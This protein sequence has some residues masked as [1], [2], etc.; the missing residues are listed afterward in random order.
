[1]PKDILS[2][3]QLRQIKRARVRHGGKKVITDDIKKLKSLAIEVD[4]TEDEKINFYREPIEIEYYIPKESRF[5]VDI[6][7]LYIR[8]VDPKPK[9]ENQEMIF[10]YFRENKKVYDVVAVMNLYPQFLMEILTA[11]EHKMSI[12]ENLSRL[13]KAGEKGE[14]TEYKKCIYILEAL[15]QY[16]PT[17]CSLNILGDYVTFGLNQLVR[18]LNKNKVEFSLEDETISYFL[19]LH[20]IY[21][22]ENNKETGERFEILSEL[23]FQQAY[24]HRGAID[25]DDLLI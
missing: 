3:S 20:R 25:L 21:D 6:K 13:I 23:F 14:L 9:N 22:E 7:Y 17:I 2:K 16:E 18:I 4:I 8:L 15:R 10:N 11:Y 19:K 5:Q 12:L 1:M 24:P